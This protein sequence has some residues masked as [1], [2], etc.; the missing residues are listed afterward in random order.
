ME[1]VVPNLEYPA[2]DNW[3]P[4]RMIVCK[5]K[6]LPKCAKSST[7]QDLP[8]YSPPKQL[9]RPAILLKLRTLKLEPMDNQSS[10]ERPEP[11]R[12]QDINVNAE[13]NRK[14]FLKETELPR[15]MNPRTEH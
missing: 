15:C 6:L 3:D 9:V 14:K 11:M 4:N 8:T 12:A 13:P 5:L 1:T 7:E 10:I 2:T